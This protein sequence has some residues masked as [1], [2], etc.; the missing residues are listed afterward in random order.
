MA[1]SDI[2]M[3]IAETLQTAHINREPSAAFDINPST[4]ADKRE[5]VELEEK[6][7]TGDTDIDGDEDDDEIPVSVL[8]PRRRFSHLPPLPSVNA[9]TQTIYF[10][11]SAF[12]LGS[13]MSTC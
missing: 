9:R 2:P 12:I 5:P 13:Q 11:L 4:A 6:T 10:V 3:Q 8:R 7:A 1:S